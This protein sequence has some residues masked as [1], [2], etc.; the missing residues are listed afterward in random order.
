MNTTTVSTKFQVVI[1]KELRILLHV[2]PGMK[3]IVTP[4][5]NGKFEFSPAPKVKNI[6]E[7]KGFLK[8]KLTPFKREPDRET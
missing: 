7:L 8:G 5:A 3:Y 1:P 4:E 2:K 6:K